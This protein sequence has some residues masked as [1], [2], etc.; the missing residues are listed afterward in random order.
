M[1][2]PPRKTTRPCYTRLAQSYPGSGGG[3]FYLAS[4]D[5]DGPLKDSWARIATY[6]MTHPEGTNSPFILRLQGVLWPAIP[7]QREFC[8]PALKDS[9]VFVSDPITMI[10]WLLNTHRFICSACSNTPYHARS[11][12]ALKAMS[13]FTSLRT[14]TVSKFLWI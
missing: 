1:W 5:I 13:S 9:E 7:N 12:A 8:L 11:I 2:G 10:L 14:M 6:F 3:S 4:P